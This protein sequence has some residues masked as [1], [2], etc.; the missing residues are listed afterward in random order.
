MACVP[1]PAL[2][3][4]PVCPRVAGVGLNVLPFENETRERLEALKLPPGTSVA[5]PIDTPV[6]T[7][8][9]KDGWVAGEILDIVYAHTRSDAVAMH[10][11]LASFA[12]RGGADPLESLLA[13][14]QTQEKWQGMAHFALALRSDGSPERDEKKRKYRA[15]AA[16]VGVPV[17]DEIPEMTHAL[18]VV[19]HIERR[20]AAAAD[21]TPR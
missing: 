18:S 10:L 1:R 20:L 17:F 5:N 9:E 13:V 6:R 19:G 3:S 2:R 11:N 21:H 16:A 15:K 4:C 14:K 7:L 8:Q 12:G